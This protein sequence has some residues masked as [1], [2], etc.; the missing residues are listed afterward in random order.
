MLGGVSSWTVTVCVAVAVLPALSVA[1]QVTVVVPTGKK[2]PAGTPVR[3]TL[4]EQPSSV[5]S[6]VPNWASPTT[7]PQAPPLLPVENVTS[8]GAVMVG[9]AASLPAAT[10]TVCVQESM[11]PVLSVAV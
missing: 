3:E 7:R 6:A 8:G 10:V 11:R 9:G 2:L 4:T 5:A 1:F